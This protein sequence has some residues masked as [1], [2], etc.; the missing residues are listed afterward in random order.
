MKHWKTKSGY[1]IILVLSGRSNVF[2]LTDGNHNILIDTSYR[3][4]RNVLEKRLDMLGIK[5]IDFLVL[6]HTH[7]DH[8]ANACRIKEKFNAKVIVH[9]SEGNY[10]TSGESTLPNGTNIFTQ[11]L[12][13]LTAKRA[14]SLVR[15]EPCQYDLLVDSFLDLWDFG[16]NAH[17]IHTPGHT[18][19][20]ISI[21]V[22]NEIAIVG[23]TMF[24][25]FPWSVFP[26][27]ANDINQLI[28]SWGKLL[29]TS[30][31]LF[32]PS[33]GSTNPRSLVQKCHLGHLG[34]HIV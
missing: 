10:L 24:G 27:F 16:F 17:I 9:K 30:C 19:G 12:I 23:D 31:S 34:T 6:T 13:R 29:D 32:L 14:N 8:A 28:N 26:P 15:C 2:L 1:Q 11:A 7:F 33:H 22:D 18:M 5:H 25:I 3:L 4:N 20:S 21:V